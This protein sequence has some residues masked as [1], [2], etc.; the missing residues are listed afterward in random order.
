MHQGPDRALD[1]STDLGPVM[2]QGICTN[3]SWSPGSA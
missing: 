3:P 2:L 1:I